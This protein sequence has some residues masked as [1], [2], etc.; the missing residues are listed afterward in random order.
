MKISY[1]VGFKSNGKITA[2]HL[3]I[4]IN[5]GISADISPTMPLNMLGALKKYDWGALSFDIKVCKTN[6]SSK[7]AMRAPGEVQASFI[8]EAVVEHVAPNLSME[9]DFVRNI[10]LHTFNS[11]YLFYEG[12]TG[13]PLEYT[14]PSIW[15]KLVRSSSFYQRTEMIKQFN[16]CNKWRKRGISWVPILH[17]VSLRPTPG[18]VSILSDGSVVVGVGGIGL[19]QGLWT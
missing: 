15:D 4:L 12:S 9:V 6:H 18:K 11:L 14:S 7:S 2:L 13:E 8:A 3:D 5:A 16:R 17:E 10:N 1:N 19:G